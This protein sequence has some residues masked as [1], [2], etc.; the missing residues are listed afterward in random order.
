MNFEFES[1]TGG[2]RRLLGLGAGAVRFS[3]LARSHRIASRSDLFIITTRPTNSDRFPL[4]RQPL[5]PASVHC[6]PLATFRL[7]MTTTP[8]LL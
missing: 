4:E 6:A 2:S 5:L 7:S 1:R 3:R 8:L